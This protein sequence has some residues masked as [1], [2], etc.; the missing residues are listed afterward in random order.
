M[1]GEAIMKQ[2]E[3]PANVQLFRY[4]QDRGISI[5]EVSEKTGYKINYLRNL[6]AGVDGLTDSAR[7]RFISSFPETIKILLNTEEK[8]N[9]K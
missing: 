2:V 5:E 4:F 3:I 8:S 6:R 9:G 7:F 1:I